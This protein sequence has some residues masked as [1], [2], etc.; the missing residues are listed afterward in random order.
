MNIEKKINEIISY[1]HEY[2]DYSGNLIITGK[3]YDHVYRM[4]VSR[5]NLARFQNT[6][7]LESLIL[8][9]IMNNKGL[10]AE[11]VRDIKISEILNLNLENHKKDIR[12]V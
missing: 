1:Y 4:Q 6:K 12:F 10:I 3:I 7:E 2:D 11:I 8:K 9:E 5:E